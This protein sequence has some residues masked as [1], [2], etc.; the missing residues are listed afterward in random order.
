MTAGDWASPLLETLAAFAAGL[1]A[2]VLAGALAA[3]ALP[4]A[5]GRAFGRGR[6]PAAAV[7]LWSVLVGLGIIVAAAAAPRG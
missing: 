6:N 1:L 2:F 7:V 3:R 4:F 5:A